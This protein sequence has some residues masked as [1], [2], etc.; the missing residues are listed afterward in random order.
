MLLLAGGCLLTQVEQRRYW[1]GSF[2]SSEWSISKCEVGC[3]EFVCCIIKVYETTDGQTPAGILLRPGDPELVI[4]VLVLLLS[5]VCFCFFNMIFHLEMDLKYSSTT[6]VDLYGGKLVFFSTCSK[7]EEELHPC[8]Y[9]TVESVT[10][11]DILESIRSS[12]TLGKRFFFTFIFCSSGVSIQK[13]NYSL[14]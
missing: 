2:K 12:I 9:F 11:L 14:K 4:K 8:I 3:L 1:T 7:W 10:A 6:V 5:Q 13:E